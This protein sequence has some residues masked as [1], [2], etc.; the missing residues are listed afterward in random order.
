MRAPALLLTLATLL[1]AGAAAAVGARVGS[2]TL[3]QCRW[4]AEA[5]VARDS[6]SP[7]LSTG[8]TRWPRDGLRVDLA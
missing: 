8:T 1:S 4:A 5:A 6:P 2:V 3:Q 7:G